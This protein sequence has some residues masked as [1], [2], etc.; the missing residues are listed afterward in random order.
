MFDLLPEWIGSLIQYWWDI[1]DW[2]ANFFT[3]LINALSIISG[4]IAVLIWLYFFTPYI[5]AFFKAI[6]SKYPNILKII[7]LFAFLNLAGSLVA[8]TVFHLHASI[9]LSVSSY[10]T[11]FTAWIIWTWFTGL[12]IM[13][14]GVLMYKLIK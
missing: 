2:S 5:I 1:S 3:D 4:F 12:F 8:F 10:I 9:I 13:T 7:I 6:I 11:P 14:I